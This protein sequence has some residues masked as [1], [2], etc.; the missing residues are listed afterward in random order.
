MVLNIVE[1]SQSKSRED[2]L[3]RDEKI[4][5]NSLLAL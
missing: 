3:E 1:S 2:V 4:I 5:R